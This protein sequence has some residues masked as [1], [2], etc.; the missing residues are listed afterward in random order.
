M[1]TF[2]TI[3]KIEEFDQTFPLLTLMYPHYSTDDFKKM[4]HDMLP[5]HYHLL[6]CKKNEEIVGLTG[7][8][9][10]VKFWS[11]KYCGID[12]FIIH[13]GYR[14]LG[15]GQLIVAKIV[16]ISKQENCKMVALDAY[17]H[18]FKAHKFFYREGFIAKGFHFVKDL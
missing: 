11:G 9:L 14:N 2:K 4:L 8:W 6:L 10:G 1:Y 15:V 3:N 17:T 5:H 7:F 12:N 13:P 16:A 18:N